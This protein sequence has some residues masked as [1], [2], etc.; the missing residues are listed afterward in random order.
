[1]Y[2]ESRAFRTLLFV[3]DQDGGGRDARFVSAA[4]VV[5]RWEGNRWSNFERSRLFFVFLT[6]LKNLE[7]VSSCLSRPLTINAEKWTTFTYVRYMLLQRCPVFV[8]RLLT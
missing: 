5:P 2:Q 7:H 1:M 4:D 3:D 8:P 6:A